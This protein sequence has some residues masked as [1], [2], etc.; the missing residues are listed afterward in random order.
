VA[1]V[2]IVTITYNHEKY[3]RKALDS[4]LSQ[5]TSFDFEILVSDD[6]STDRTPLIVKEY[7]EKYPKIIKPFLA[8]KNVGSMKNYLNTLDRA[9]SEYVAVC[10][11]D[12]YWC[13]N[14]KLQM[15]VDFLD[16]NKDYSICFNQTKVIFEDENKPEEMF[17]SETFKKTTEIK[18]LIKENFIPA[19]TVMYRWAFRGREKISDIIPYDVTPGDYFTNL[20]HANQGKIYF[21][22]RTMSCY[23][24][25]SGGIWWLTSQDG[26]QD[27]FIMKFGLSHL[28]FFVTAEKVLKLD[29]KTYALQKENLTNNLI[30]CYLDKKMFS[31]L[32]DLRHNYKKLFDACYDARGRRSPIIYDSLSILRKITYLAVVDP[33]TLKRKAYQRIKN[34][35]LAHYIYR[36]SKTTISKV[37]NIVN[38]SD[39]I[40][41]KRR[42]L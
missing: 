13:D 20:I 14:D 32:I 9:K 33:L 4:I 27:K 40:K 34:N 6:H 7:S 36:R 39:K 35:K 38:R 17:P 23:R 2:S 37:K 11:G 12:D 19:N 15:Q 25:H 5:K 41:S 24:R 28:K 42:S 26:K 16:S 30:G 21:I 31:E 18:D 3:I 29:E 22:N 8:K 1:K 10:D